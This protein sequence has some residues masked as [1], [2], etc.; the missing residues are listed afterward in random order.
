MPREISLQ[1]FREILGR[2]RVIIGAEPVPSTG[3]PL[4]G[5]PVC[6]GS[7]GEPIRRPDS[8]ISIT[9]DELFF[10]S[11]GS[12]GVLVVGDSRKA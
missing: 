2:P 4:I 12:R 9:I 3:A 1:E 6:T 8:V 5:S 11:H 7:E 10:D